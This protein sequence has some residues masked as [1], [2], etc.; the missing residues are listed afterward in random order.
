[1][2]ATRAGRVVGC[3]ARWDQRR[4]KQVVVRG[5]SRRIARWRPF[6][7]AA[8]R[9]LGVPPLP[10][11]GDRLELAYLSH[12]AVDG[13]NADVAVAL[14]AAARCGLAPERTSSPRGE[15]CPLRR[16]PA[17][18]PSPRE[19]QLLYLRTGQTANSCQGLDGAHHIRSGDPMGRANPA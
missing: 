16:A 3:V 14:V 1:M 7:N 17:S 11:V 4:F 9:W 18:L 13:D 2:V 12:L 5:Y 10:A 6:V 15:R 19:S 8:G